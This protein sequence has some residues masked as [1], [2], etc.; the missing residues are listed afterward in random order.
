MKKD[1]TLIELLAGIV[2]IGVLEQV[3]LLLFFENHLYNAIGVWCGILVSVICAIHMKRSIEDAVDLGDTERATKYAT[4]GY[5]TRMAIT[6]VLVGAVLY[7]EVGNP[8]TVLAGVFA[9]KLAAYMQPFMHKVFLKLQEK[10][11]GT[12]RGN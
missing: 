9:L 7:F 6:A 4:K 11:G 1:N 3:I 5:I 12:L 8:I 2:C 10:K